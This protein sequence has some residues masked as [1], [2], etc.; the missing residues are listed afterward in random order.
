MAF[1]NEVIE[2]EGKIK[3]GRLGVFYDKE[4][5]LEKLEKHTC[6][7]TILI[8]KISVPKDEIFDQKKEKFGFCKGKYVHIVHIKEVKIQKKINIA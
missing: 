1:P 2:E 6:N 8:V 7:R 3:N 4:K 5:L